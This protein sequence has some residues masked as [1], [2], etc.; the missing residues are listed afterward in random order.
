[1]MTTEVRFFIVMAVA[2]IVL[3]ARVWRVRQ[4]RRAPVLSGAKGHVQVYL[5]WAPG[6]AACGAQKQILESLRSR[7]DGRMSVQHVNAAEERALVD[8][9]AVRTVPATVIVTDEGAVER[10][11]GLV[12]QEKLGTL[13]SMQDE[14]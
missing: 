13:L 12:T 8:R 3:G 14:H 6:C 1:M 11:H 5:F 10:L 9:Y 4:N 2:V 7:S